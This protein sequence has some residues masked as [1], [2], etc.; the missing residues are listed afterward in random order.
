MK[1]RFNRKAL[2]EMDRSAEK[3]EW[4]DLV[5]ID[6]IPAFSAWLSCRHGFS[7]QSPD[8]GEALSMWRDGRSIKVFFDGRTTRCRRGVMALW[9]S[10]ACFC[11]KK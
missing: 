4:I 9:L 5:E 10:F 3:E 6:K 2:K 8:A 1:K 11:L 7:P